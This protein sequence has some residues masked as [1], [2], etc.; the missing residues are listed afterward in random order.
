MDFLRRIPVCRYVNDNVLIH[1]LGIV[2]TNLNIAVGILFSTSGASATRAPGAASTSVIY[3]TSALTAVAGPASTDNAQT[4]SGFSYASSTSTVGAQPVTSNTPA[5]ALTTQDSKGGIGVGAIVGI[6]FGAITIVLIAILVAFLIWRQRRK[7]PKQLTPGTMSIQEVEAN[8]RR[9]DVDKE[10]NPVTTT[11]AVY[12]PELFAEQA[13]YAAQYEWKSFVPE[14][15]GDP[16]YP[17]QQLSPPKLDSVHHLS[18]SSA[19]TELAAAVPSEV[20]AST[21]ATSEYGPPY[22]G[23]VE[24][25]STY[26][27]HITSPISELGNISYEREHELSATPH[28]MSQSPLMEHPISAAEELSSSPAARPATTLLA[29]RSSLGVTGVASGTDDVEDAELNRMKAEIEAVRAE[30]ER[31]L[32]LQAL[33]ERE[34]ELSRKIVNRELSKG[35]G[36]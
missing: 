12:I 31:V 25:D 1:R 3:Q 7:Q 15:I 21:Q 6:A 19:N 14:V 11:S 24:V 17:S 16:R 13:I 33:E 18:P 26:Q 9:L 10:V 36:S 34:R 2:L 4:A 8:S 27:S 22:H 32:H 5:S 29:A 30:K 28:M 23:S 35:A 20:A